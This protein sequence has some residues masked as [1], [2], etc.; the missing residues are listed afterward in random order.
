[1]P[2]FIYLLLI[3]IGNLISKYNTIISSDLRKL[4]KLLSLY[5]YIILLKGII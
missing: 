1:M 4:Y 3:F 2:P 5:Y